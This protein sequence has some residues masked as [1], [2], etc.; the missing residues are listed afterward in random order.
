MSTENNENMEIE[1]NKVNNQ[2]NKIGNVDAIINNYDIEKILSNC[3]RG[4]RILKKIN[5]KLA[6][7]IKK[8]RQ[9]GLI[10]TLKHPK[11]NNPSQPNNQQNDKLKVEKVNKSDKS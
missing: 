2:K 3:S 9:M 6:K 5:K 1:N 4:G 10:H 7:S 11:S 8:F